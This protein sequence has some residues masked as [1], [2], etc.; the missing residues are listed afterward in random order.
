MPFYIFESEKGEIVEKFFHMMENKQFFGPDG[1]FWRRIYLKPQM[2][3]DSIIKDPL[4]SKEFINNSSRKTGVLG[5]L[6]EQ[7][8]ELSQ[9]REK[10]CGLD[11]IK[12]KYIKNWEKKRKRLHPENRKIKCKNELDKRGVILE[13]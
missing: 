2:S 8:A 13:D 6:I 1:K 9:K 7:S 3:I 12:S 5:D 4:S 10:L 11:P